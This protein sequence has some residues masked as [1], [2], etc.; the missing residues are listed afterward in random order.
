MGSPES[1]RPDFWPDR[2][3]LQDSDCGEAHPGTPLPRRASRPIPW[4][5]VLSRGGLD[6]TAI[7]N[8]SGIKTLGFYKKQ[9][10]TLHLLQYV[11]A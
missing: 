9:N 8:Y 3:P 7:L 1:P 10:K 4:V 2:Y 11:Q 5:S 6:P